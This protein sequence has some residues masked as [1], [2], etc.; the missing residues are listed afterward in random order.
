MNQKGKSMFVRNLGKFKKNKLSIFGFIMFVII[1]FSSVFAPFLT[2]Y[3]PQKID[4]AT[5][6]K[7]PSA[8]HILGTDKLGRDVF[9]RLLYG[10]RVSIAVGLC[11]ALSGAFIGTVLGCIGGYFGSKIDAFLVRMSEVFLTFPNMIVI[12]LL[13]S[14]MGK[15]LLNI[16]IVFSLTG[17]M[18]TFRMVR[19]EFISLKQETYVEVCKSFGIS[20]FRIMFYNI[21]PNAISPVVVAISLNT[22]LFILAEA[23]LSY[24]GLGVPS[25][26]PTWGNIINAA[27][28]NDVISNAW[29]LWLFPGAIISLFVLS[30]NFLGD[31]LR[32]LMDPN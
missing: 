11:G 32:D 7:P 30:V 27:K 20:D 10:G 17:W 13:V 4:M 14:I 21:L 19:N 16:I 12:I 5:V 2:S 24:L 26:I 29:W 8:E 31:G 15:G 25:N 18:T 6:S 1:L 28:S 22:A 3:D 23:G 9:S